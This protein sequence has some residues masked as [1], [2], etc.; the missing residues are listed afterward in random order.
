MRLFGDWR[1][2]EG[3][4]VLFVHRGEKPLRAVASEMFTA[5]GGGGLVGGR[6]FAL[7]HRESSQL[8][9]TTCFPRERRP[10]G[11]IVWHPGR[12]NTASQM[13]E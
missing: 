6:V 11:T 2:E 10:S 1:G 12:I 9:L 5:L 3:Y 13:P 7:C 4:Q 8:V